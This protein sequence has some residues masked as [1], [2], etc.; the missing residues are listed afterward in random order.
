MNGDL[1]IGLDSSTQSTKAVA[2]TRDGEAVAEGRAAIPM[3][4]PAPGF[5]EQDVEDWW[6]AACT[7]LR[8]LMA[9]VEATRIAGLAI[10]NQRETVA[11]VD[12]DLQAVRPAIV[13]LDERAMDEIP[14]LTAALGADRLHATSGKPPDITPVVYRLSWLRRHEPS[15]LEAARILDVHGFLTG[16]L[17]GHPTASWTSADPFGLFDIQAK[18][19]SAPILAQLGLASDRFAELARPGTQ[20]GCVGAEAAGA[21]GLARGTPVFAAGGDG[22]CA[23]LGV[24]AVRPGLVYLNLGTAIITGGWSPT[25][26]IGRAWRTM[27]SPTG[28]GYFLEGCQRAGAFF[29]N[30]FVDGF[31]GGRD[32]PGVFARL[33][34]AAAALPVGSEGVVV[35]PYLSGVMDPHWNPQA[36]AGFLGL[37]ASHGIGHL[38]RASL[39]AMTLES[40][41]CVAAMADDGLTPQRILAVGGGANSALWIQMIADATGL[42]IDLSESLE[43]S[44]LGAAMSAAVGLGWF[45][46]FGEAADIMSRTGA[47]VMPNRSARAAWDALSVRQAAAYR[48]TLL[49]R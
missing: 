30:W 45:A 1:I 10:S 12:D 5:A 37:S 46:D 29:I 26:R 35:C 18:T 20:I 21:T 32:D 28:E 16:R 39:E 49:E 17:T 15:A 19:W 36:R 40:A 47:T 9:E 42:P 31:A 27:T 44:S 22:Q 8:A 33:E 7:A 43:A 2:W 13:W 14:L 3:E 38:Y 6:R 4:T 34:A 23:G 25:P 11:F 24:N 41:R 48:A